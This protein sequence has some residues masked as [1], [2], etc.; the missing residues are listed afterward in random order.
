ME[1]IR[2]VENIR[3]EH[4]GCVLT[5][6]NFDGIHLGHQAII[7]RL[8]SRGEHYQLPSCVM[9]FEPQPQELFLGQEAPA[10][11]SCLREK[12]QAL[13]ELG[14]E[15]LLC[16]RFT[17]EFAGMDAGEFIEKLLIERLGVKSLLVGDDFCFGRDRAGDFQML[18]EAGKRHQFEVIDSHSILVDQL[19]VSST[20][21]RQALQQ[22]AFD[23]ARRML[24]R[25][26]AISGRVCHGDELGRT[27]GFPTANIKPSR[28]VLPMVGV[29]VVDVIWC[30]NR[31]PAV[32]NIGFR[33]TLDG[34]QPR[35]EVHLF[36]FDGDLYGQ[37]LK[38][39]F[40]HK[41]RDEKKFDSFAQLQQQISR[42]AAAAR[43]YFE[44]I[45]QK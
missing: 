40:R 38:V 1:L 2:G 11:L 39:V 27:I 42:D 12:Y 34:L 9:V 15:R 32:A 4:H 22:G 14:V 35:L 8:K 29:Y 36:D 33:P 5:I 21:V 26:Y 13:R 20:A 17:P 30:S 41:L 28:L 16:I 23:E 31:Y 45:S 43:Q 19:R 44:S 18:S 6:G 24:G 7:A 3:A 37:Q 10:R 25:D